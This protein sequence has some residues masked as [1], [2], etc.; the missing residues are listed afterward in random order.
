MCLLVW[1]ATRVCARNNKQ[2]SAWL[3]IRCSGYCRPA[4]S[5]LWILISDK[6][7]NHTATYTT[8]I[9]LWLRQYIVL[10]TPECTC[11]LS[12]IFR[13]RWNTVY[14]VNLYLTHI[15]VLIAVQSKYSVNVNVTDRL[16]DK[17]NYIIFMSCEA[18]HS[19][20]HGI[21]HCETMVI[22]M[23]VFHKLNH[24]ERGQRRTIILL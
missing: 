13:K 24:N 12:C 11:P 4:R 7:L 3:M 15:S 1:A 19:D 18:M 8:M 17:Y 22:H 14:S 20:K 10:C 9:K 23:S 5:H 16:P 6:M 2:V 21:R